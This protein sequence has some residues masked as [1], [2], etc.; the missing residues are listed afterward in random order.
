MS[1]NN[2]IWAYLSD[3]ALDAET[4]KSISHDVASFLQHWKAHGNPLETSYRILHHRFIVISVNEA[5]FSASGCS[6]DKQVQFIKETEKKYGINL[7]N[8]LLVAYLNKDTVEVVHSS[9]IPELLNAGAIDENTTVFN[10]AVSNQQEFDSSWQVPL[11][12]S[13]LSRFLKKA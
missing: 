10:A 8:R 1:G 7:L 13:W 6:I 9:K 11:K 3:K 5:E 12:E 2:K 4:E